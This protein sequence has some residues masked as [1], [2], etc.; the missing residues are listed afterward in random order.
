VSDEEG[1]T[2][3]Y[4]ARL[5][6]RAAQGDANAFEVLVDRHRAAVY[7]FARAI[8]RDASDAEEVL[9]ETFLSAWRGAGGFAGRSS[10]RTWLLVI[11]RNGALRA[12][13]RAEARR[14]D[15]GESLVELGARAGF[16]AE[17]PERIALAAERRGVLAAALASLGAEDREILALRDLEEI[18][19]EECAEALGLSVP[20]MKSRLHR[21]RLRLVAAV[22][23]AAGDGRSR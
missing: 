5:V 17:D 23:D 3:E 8:A 4:D 13:G 19:G 14:E 11:A 12:R 1:L 22:R 20:A 18:P 21:A 7:R 6:A 2:G 15:G 10:V 16:G 9:Q